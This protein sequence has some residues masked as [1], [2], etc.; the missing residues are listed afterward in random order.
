MIYLYIEVEFN[1]IPGNMIYTTI[2]VLYPSNI[3]Q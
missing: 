2:N 1:Y 3:T